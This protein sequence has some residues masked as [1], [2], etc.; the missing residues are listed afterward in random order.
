M[1][2]HLVLQSPA[3]QVPPDSRQYAVMEKLEPKDCMIPPHFLREIAPVLAIQE[4]AYL[5]S[6]LL[7][8]LTDFPEMDIIYGDHEIMY[9]YLL[10][11]QKHCKSCKVPLRI[12]VGKGMMHCWLAMD[13]TPEGKK[14]RQDVFQ[15]LNR[16][17]TN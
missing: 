16:S 14:A 7:F 15:M 17:Q 5:L 9:A 2:S 8:D 10:D 1:P 3:M 11:L 6:P 4:E 13:M 12:H